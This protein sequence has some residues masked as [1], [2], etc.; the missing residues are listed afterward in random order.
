MEINNSVLY[1]GVISIAVFAVLS[2]LR[3][4]TI[5][6]SVKNLGGK[7]SDVFIGKEIPFVKV[8]KVFSI[9]IFMIALVIALARPK[10][11]ERNI[12]I[13]KVGVDIVVALDISKSMLAN[14]VKPTR[15][16]YAKMVIDHIL[17]N[18][19]DAR[20][21]LM[22]YASGAYVLSPITEDRDALNMFLDD[23]DLNFVTSGGTDFYSMAQKADDMLVDVSKSKTLIVISDGEDHSD[24]FSS[25]IS[26]LKEKKIMAITIG[27]GT[28]DGSPISFK[29]RNGNI[30]YVKDKND[31]IVYSKLE[32]KNL[33]KLASETNGKYFPISGNILETEKVIS[34]I[35]K[36]DKSDI[37][38]K[39]KIVKADQYQVFLLI[40][41]VF[42]VVYILL[43][44]I[45]R[46]KDYEY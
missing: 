43:Y 3:V 39:K 32:D 7:L 5:S 1:I 34:F 38:T 15:I 45:K 11:G 22:V 44:N 16:E 35:K 29:D 17:E 23:I 28:K 42:F 26:L 24:N 27:I 9:S 12:E 46:K 6:K 18:T 41:I 31:K 8:L 33:I 14:D 25:V 2:I 36:L 30:K 37:D 19:K 10:F 13:K 21:G 20:I 40:S 4:R